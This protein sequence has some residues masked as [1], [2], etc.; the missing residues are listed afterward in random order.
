MVKKFQPIN[1][2]LT[3]IEPDSACHIRRIGLRELFVSP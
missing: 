2:E 3:L 1:D